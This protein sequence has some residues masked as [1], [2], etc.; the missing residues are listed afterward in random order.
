MPIE[1]DPGDPVFT[2][3]VAAR[4]TRL[5]HKQL[6]VLEAKEIVTPARSDHQHRL[7]SLDQLNLLRYVSYLVGTRKVNAAGVRVVLELLERMPEDERLRVLEEA[8]EAVP[9][10]ADLAPILEAEGPDVSSE[11]VD[12]QAEALQ[13]DGEAPT[14][15]TS[16]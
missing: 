13:V 3:G 4:L 15:G 6:R 5:S 8:D 16:E 1:I 9:E 14:S 10:G 7:Y 2:I 11:G 12:G